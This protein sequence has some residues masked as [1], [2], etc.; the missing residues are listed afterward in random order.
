MN[1][2]EM[3]DAFGVSE[4]TA[5][6][7]IARG[8]TPEQTRTLGRDGKTY[9]GLRDAYPHSFRPGRPSGPLAADLIMARNAVRRLAR[10]SAF[11]P[12]DLAE[13][14]TIAKEAA[15]LL[16]EWTVA[17]EADQQARMIRR[18]QR[19]LMLTSEP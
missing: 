8:T 19:R 6:R 13:L 9:A 11:S 5:R 3:A 18:P 7:H 17:V 16:V 12:D 1:T 10:A 2:K 14:R 4:R 15:D